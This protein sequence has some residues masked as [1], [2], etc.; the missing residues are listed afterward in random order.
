MFSFFNWCLGLFN[1][2]TEYIEYLTY[3]EKTQRLRPLRKSDISGNEPIKWLT[4]YDCLTYKEQPECFS[5]LHKSDISGNEPIESEIDDN[6]K[7]DI[8][9]SDY[10]SIQNKDGT[11]VFKTDHKK[12]SGS[13]IFVGRAQLG[14][15]LNDTRHRL[16]CVFDDNGISDV[17]A[18][19][20][21]M[22]ALGH[23]KALEMCDG[24]DRP[25]IFFA[26]NSPWKSKEKVILLTD[27][28][29][30]H[31]VSDLARHLNTIQFLASRDT[32]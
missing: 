25:H 8:D 18:E 14:G 28:L 3:K 2:L 5:S 10:V 30:H 32:W 15:P 9:L 11:P 24:L 27:A 6:Q 16:L 4:Y 22:F 23:E 20:S 31:T 21:R 29:K 17:E 26:H 12:A 1:E 13:P 7:P 19:L